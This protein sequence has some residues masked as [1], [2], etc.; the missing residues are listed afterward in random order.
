MD[1][2]NQFRPAALE[3]IANANQY[4]TANKEHITTGILLHYLLGKDEYPSVDILK[5]VH[6]LTAED[7]TRLR[8]AADE[9]MKVSAKPGNSVAFTQA[10][11]DSFRSALVLALKVDGSPPRM[12]TEHMLHAI[13]EADPAVAGILAAFNVSP[14]SYAKAIMEYARKGSGENGQRRPE[15]AMAGR[16]QFSGSRS[17]GKALAKYTTD[18]TA[19]AQAGELDPVLCREKETLRMV[20]VL[21]R[22]TKNNPVLVGDPGSGKTAIA[23]GLAQFLLTDEAPEK[24]RNKKVLSLD[25]SG[26]IAG[27]RYRGDFEERLTQVTNEI[28]KAGNIIL[29][30]DE[31]HTIVGA[32]GAEGSMDAANM[33][34]PLLSKGSLRTVGATTLKEYRK[35]IESDAALTRRFQPV[36]VEEPTPDNA[37]LML[38]GI[39]AKY[40]DF[41]EIVILPEALEA[42]VR[43]SSRYINDRQLPDKAIDV[44]DEAAARLALDSI[45]ELRRS[46]KIEASPVE[47]GRVEALQSHDFKRASELKKESE[48][49]A[50]KY[51]NDI[52]IPVLTADHII[53][54]ISDISGVPQSAMKVED[55]KKA[56]RLEGELHKRIIGQKE[57]IS[58]LARSVRRQN[59]GLK[60][61]NRPAGSFIFAGPTGTGKTELS[62]ALA[63]LLVD[64]EKALITF[65]MSEYGEKH[66][67]SRLIGSPP[68]Y[69]GHDEGGQLT[70]AV[71]RRPYSVILLD[72]IEKAH[73][74]IYN[75]LL[76]VL[77]EGRLTDSKGVEVNFKNT[78]IIMTTNLGT[79][80]G[81]SMNDIG[82]TADPDAS[83]Y[84]RLFK[85]V[86]A[87]LK[88]NMRP[89][90]LNRLD[91]IIVFSHLTKE[92]VR[93]VAGLLLKG[94]ASRLVESNG[95]TLEVTDR[96]M[97]FLVEEG[98]DRSLGARPMKRA[99]QRHIEDNISERI[100]FGS[101]VPG[102]NIIVDVSEYSNVE[103]AEIIINGVGV[104]EF[105]EIMR[106]ALYGEDEL[107]AI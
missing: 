55:G 15:E 18:L 33:L 11:R 30:I 36:M 78:I 43:L 105:N 89:E 5:D 101:V 20:R 61:P 53:A 29:F 60:D 4:A 88:E 96:M 50:S 52:S 9:Y 3:V 83:A 1:N 69:I 25:L 19:K 6:K 59:S 79:S 57:A 31:L 35:Y 38:Q 74:D 34:K 21:S 24:L 47:S 64:D 92:E 68:G 99:I 86:N 26:M 100:L 97:D 104:N 103:E 45:A 62:K 10:V 23:E 80:L 93:Q 27:S 37:I 76:Q 85:S 71:R 16:G 87:A 46:S 75:V 91:N 82:F 32:G 22:R 94:L 12:G 2:S 106:A 84:Q 67:V 48:R 44:L 81:S 8:V 49:I 70:E 39:Q 95:N 63:K 17:S 90:L 54:V 77:D 65:D 14:E 98:Y 58:S 66:T 51:S 7:V 41:H 107:T 73:P 102:D 28:I 72:E 42:A 40:Q 13:M 56:L